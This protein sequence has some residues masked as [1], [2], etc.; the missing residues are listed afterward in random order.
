M[1]RIVPIIAA[2]RSLVWAWSHD[3]C[4]ISVD[5]VG[6]LSDWSGPCVPCRNSGEGGLGKYVRRSPARLSNSPAPTLDG[7]TAHSKIFLTG[8]RRDRPVALAHARHDAAFDPS[9]IALDRHRS[10]DLRPARSRRQRWPARRRSRPRRCRRGANS[11]GQIRGDPPI[12]G[13]TVCAAI[14]R[15][16]AGRSGRPLAAV[17]R[18]PRWRYRA[19]WRRSHRTAPKVRCPSRRRQ[20]RARSPR[21][22]AAALR[23][24]VVAAPAAMSMPMPT[25][26]REFRQ[27]RQQQAAG[28]GAEIE[29]AR[30]ARRGRRSAR[31]PPRRGSRSPAAG[32]AYRPTA[33]IAGPRIRASRGCGST[34]RR[35]TIRASE[36]AQTLGRSTVSSA[37]SGWLSSS[38]GDS[39]EQASDAAGAPA[40]AA[41]R[42]PAADSAAAAS[43]SI[44]PSV[45]ATAS[46]HSSTAASRAAWSSASSASMISSSAS[47]L[48]TLSIL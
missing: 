46:A 1:V 8:A 44:E 39:S 36:S 33:Q 47:P 21:P 5:T 11:A 32:R 19:G 10:R 25:G 35:R 23:R 3:T 20:N 31:A 41:R 28:A 13:K 30:A 4:L 9:E 14:E 17:R 2:A 42:D 37:R 29:K 12:G 43:A 48:I 45:S 16:A 18:A 40:G 7:T 24:A 38:V 27:Q 26:G 15:R 22:S 34:A 6:A